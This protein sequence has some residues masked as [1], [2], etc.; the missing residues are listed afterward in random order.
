ML[1]VIDACGLRGQRVAFVDTSGLRGPLRVGDTL[2]DDVMRTYVLVSI[3]FV[4][5]RT[6][7]DLERHRDEVPIVLRPVDGMDDGPTGDLRPN[8]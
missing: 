7:E 6:A 1:R 2:V 8:A 3:G 5:Y 4:R